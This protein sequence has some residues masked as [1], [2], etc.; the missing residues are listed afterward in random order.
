MENGKKIGVLV[1]QKVATTGN[2]GKKSQVAGDIDYVQKI[3]VQNCFQTA[4][5]LK[6]NG[7]D[8]YYSYL[9]YWA[10]A[11]DDVGDDDD[12]DDMMLLL[13]MR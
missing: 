10:D 9:W 8:F 12:D 4:D 13:L 5:Q 7:L 1:I 2:N 11:I 3:E 6:F